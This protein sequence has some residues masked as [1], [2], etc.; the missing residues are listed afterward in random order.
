MTKEQALNLTVN[1]FTNLYDNTVLPSASVRKI[2][3]YYLELIENNKPP[4][5]KS[6]LGNIELCFQ[7][8]EIQE[9]VEEQEDYLESIFYI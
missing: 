8:E 5:T 7:E 3:N 9:M 4:Q 1:K 2:I 6:S